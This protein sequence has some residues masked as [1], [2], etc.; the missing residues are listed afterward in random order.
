MKGFLNF[1]SSLFY[2][3]M[4]RQKYPV[5]KVIAS[6]TLDLKFPVSSFPGMYVLQIDLPAQN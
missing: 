4:F 5:Q 2:I 1:L 6:F 3:F